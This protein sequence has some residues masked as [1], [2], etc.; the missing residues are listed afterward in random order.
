MKHVVYKTMQFPA[1]WTT[2]RPPNSGPDCSLQHSRL[3]SYFSS[4]L[5]RQCACKCIILCR[6]FR[7]NNW[8]PGSLPSNSSFNWLNNVFKISKTLL[9]HKGWEFVSIH[10]LLLP[11]HISLNSFVFPTNK[12]LMIHCFNLLYSFMFLFQI[13]KCLHHGRGCDF[14]NQGKHFHAS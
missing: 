9:N 6:F 10:Y 13:L 5:W 14:F 1:W 8:L 12:D 7:R 2:D 3:G 11:R 4:V